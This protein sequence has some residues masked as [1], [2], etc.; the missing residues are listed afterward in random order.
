[1]KNFSSLLAFVMMF[2]CLSTAYADVA[3]PPRERNVQSDF[4]TATVEDNGNL[5]LKFE[6]PYECNYAYQL[7]DKNTGA[8]IQAGNGSYKIGDTVEKF[9]DLSGK[10]G[11]RK[12]FFLL[13]TQMSNI[14]V[15]TR[16]GPKIRD[17]SESV[18]KTLLIEYSAWVERY[19]LYV[20]DGDQ[21]GN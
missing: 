15:Y 14:K 11:R 20:Y 4:L 18:T 12:N 6:F 17:G 9:A 13:K 2:A 7:I 19:G 1:M 16:F 3:L 5:T 10:L 21:T 8:T